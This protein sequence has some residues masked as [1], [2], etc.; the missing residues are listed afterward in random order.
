MRSGNE[1]SKLTLGILLSFMLLPT[2]GFGETHEAIP[3]VSNSEICEE[4]G[5]GPAVVAIST[6]RN[7]CTGTLI[8]PQVIL[9]AAHCGSFAKAEFTHHMG[10]GRTENIDHCK[11][12]PE[13]NQRTSIWDF[14]YCVLEN[15]VTD[16]PYIPAAFGCEYDLF[17]EEEQV[18]TQ[19]GFGYYNDDD[20]DYFK[21]YAES[22][23][24][25]VNGGNGY[26]LLT[27]G[28]HKGVVACPGDSGGP[29]LA[30][31]ADGSWRT[32]GILST[33]SGQCGGKGSN[34]YAPIRRAIEWVEEDSGIDVTP[35]FSANGDWYPTEDCG[36]FWA[37]PDNTAYG[38]WSDGCPETPVSGYSETCGVPYPD[39]EPD[40]DTGS[41]SDTDSD[42][43]S[44][45]D[46]DSD[47]DND[48]D[49][50]SDTEDEGGSDDDG[51]CGC[52]SAGNPS[53]TISLLHLLQ[54]L[55]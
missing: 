3:I 23:I 26:G 50:D 17:I 37:S 29:L 22:K 7:F 18:V 45:S 1:K 41:D 53:T 8:H 21:R 11:M 30:R 10:S 43:D 13:Y 51:N 34:V 42:A 38:S 40:T 39:F 33:F 14:G 54:R 48:S 9:T 16:I 19:C 55:F 46:S 2:N 52:V 49:S 27:V 47:S 25:D 4:C 35:C 32:I 6:G 36:G 15:P 24:T 12:N 31:V 20:I 5:F 44:D 28:P